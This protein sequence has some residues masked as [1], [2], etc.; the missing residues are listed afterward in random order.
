MTIKK[1]V[2]NLIDWYMLNKPNATDT[3]V[4]DCSASFIAKFAP[5]SITH[6][7]IEKKGKPLRKR[8]YGP[9][10]YRGYKIVRAKKDDPRYKAQVDAFR[11]AVA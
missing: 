5:C 6:K 8:A 4:L 11:S 9:R 10:I 1:Q 2:D 3:I 7:E